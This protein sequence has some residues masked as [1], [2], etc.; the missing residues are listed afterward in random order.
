[1]DL[2]RFIMQGGLN[3]KKCKHPYGWYRRPCIIQV[4]HIP[5]LSNNNLKMHHISL[6]RS[7]TLRRN[8]ERYFMIEIKTHWNNLWIKRGGE[9]DNR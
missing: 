2:S 3:M 4:D 9:D 7:H 1:M 6:L 5:G 8:W